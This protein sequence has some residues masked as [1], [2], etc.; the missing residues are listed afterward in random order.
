[1]IANSI[2]LTRQSDEFGSKKLSQVIQ[3]GMLSQN[4]VPYTMNHSMTQSLNLL[5]SK[6]MAVISEGQEKMM[7]VVGQSLLPEFNLQM[8]IDGLSD[9]SVAT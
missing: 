4:G 8:K 1:M 3:V 7:R 5:Q 6:V 9:S 2:L